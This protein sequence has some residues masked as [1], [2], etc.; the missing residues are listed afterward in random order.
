M[1]SRL[2][3]TFSS[4]KYPLCILAGL[5]VTAC[6][7]TSSNGSSAVEAPNTIRFTKHIVKDPQQSAA[8]ID[9]HDFDKDGVKE[10]VLSTLVE[11]LPPGPPN[12]TA[13]GALRIFK[14]DSGELDG[15]WSEETI[16][17]TTDI[18]GFPFINT[19][20]VMDVNQDGHDDIVVQTGFLFTL[21]G[22][23]FWQAGP[24]LASL[25]SR[26]YFSLPETHKLTS[27]N[28]FWHETEQADLDGDGLLDIITTSG[29]TQRLD[30]PLGT[31]DDN[32]LL[33]VEWF[34]NNGDGSFSFYKLAED[35]GGVFIKLHDIDGDNDL[36]IALSQFFVRSTG[37]PAIVWMEN[38]EAPAADNG[39]LGKW[40]VHTIDNTIGL[41]YHMEFVDIDHD[42]DIELV[43]GNHN[44]QDDP[45]WQDENGELVTPPG[46]YIFEIPDDPRAS[47][48]WTR[49]VISENFRVGINWGSNPGSQGVP[50]IFNVGDINNDGRLD[51]AVP[52]DGNDSLYAFI[53]N[54]D[55][56]FSEHIVEQGHFTYGMAMVADVNGDGRNEIVAANHNATNGGTTLP[57]GF[58][59]I[60]AVEE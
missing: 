52:G 57:P 55:G 34:R 31:P 58:L 38:Q 19:P 60:Y 21:G 39:Y 33:R 50:G 42:G 11:F 51:V 48:Q 5:L 25:S 20:Q 30:N 41:G 27:Q 37:E 46:M 54:R 8:F 13:R 47:S 1:S 59:A 14:S 36:D 4:L 28:Y 56:S 22:A 23:Y 45:R 44:N 43:A 15:P 12:A 53:Q 7:D 49:R 6:A 3:K 26:N 17:S 35:I 29:A 9:V 24:D 18:E 2:P 32:R 40:A 10:I 16:I